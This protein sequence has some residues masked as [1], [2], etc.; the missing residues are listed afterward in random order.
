LTEDIFVLPNSGTN[1]LDFFRI[2]SKET[3]VDTKPTLVLALPRL[4]SGH[5]LGGIS[6]RAE[7]N[8]IGKAS[9]FGQ[10]SPSTGD[11]NTRSSSISSIPIINDAS[12]ANDLEDSAPNCPFLPKPIDAVCLF[13][14]RIFMVQPVLVQGGVNI[15]VQFRNRFSFVAHR[16]ALMDLFEKWGDGKWE[17]QEKQRLE[18]LKEERRKQREERRKERED[19]KKELEAIKEWRKQMKKEK[20]DHQNSLEVDTMQADF[21]QE[22]DAMD[23]RSDREP[24][25]S[26][27]IHEED[28]DQPPP[29]LAISDSDDS[30]INIESD[31]DTDT[32]QEVNTLSIRSMVPY[33]E[34]GPNITR[35]FNSDHV[36]THW[37]TTTAGERCVR[38]AESP[39]GGHPYTIV[40]FNQ[41]NVKKVKDMLKR[42]EAR[43]V[44]EKA[45]AAKNAKGKAKEKA[46]DNNSLK[47]EEQGWKGNCDARKGKTT[48]LAHHDRQRRAAKH[49]SPGDADI[50]TSSYSSTVAGNADSQSNEPLTL[51][52]DT[53]SQPGSTTAA[54][55]GS[56]TAPSLPSPSDPEFFDAMYE[57]VPGLTDVGWSTPSPP[58]GDAPSDDVPLNQAQIMQMLFG[59]GG[60]QAIDMDDGDDEWE[61]AD[62]DMDEDQEFFSDYGDH[63]SAASDDI[64]VVPPG[65]ELNAMIDGGDF[66]GNEQGQNRR[67]LER[68]NEAY[69]TIPSSRIRVEDEM[70]QVMPSTAFSEPVEGRLPYV[71]ITTEEVFPFNGILLDEERVIGVQVRSMSFAFLICKI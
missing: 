55:A 23:T 64:V 63:E 25:S 3:T 44:E 20:L 22:D 21:N 11:S 5:H 34:W 71:A 49:A 60:A 29:L 40:D 4:A 47:L 36:G 14:L 26:T 27:G 9:K 35:W 17:E 8:P 42:K 16:R 45:E 31:S 58:P 61:D 68:E 6:C 54:T 19:W 59:P 70:R 37:I 53:V 66:D 32:D 57:D 69:T 30:S 15:Q 62:D 33:G 7:P 52:E 51:T 39:R 12:L 24:S 43:E 56:S 2:P 28:D 38:M 46:V 41:R 67:R 50:G 48:F 1:A 18:M 13:D 10:T 65:T